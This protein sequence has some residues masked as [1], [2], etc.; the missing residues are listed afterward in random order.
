MYECTFVILGATGDLTKR[1]LIPAIYK[2]IEDKKIE[3]FSLIGVAITDT[4]SDTMLESAKGFIDHINEK[5]WEKLKKASYFSK[6]DFYNFEDYKNLRSL[7]DQVEKK[8]DLKG[9]RLFY[10]ATMP[11]HFATI[12]GA[13]AQSGIVDKKD[14]HKHS[15]HVGG[16]TRIVYEKPFGFDLKS[17]KKINREISKIF[18][19]DQI[20]RIDH[21]LG[22][23]VVGDIA[24]LRFTNRV[25]E[26]LWN[27]NN[28]DSVQIIM[29]EKIGIEGRGAF[30]DSCG[31][32]CDMIQSHMLQILSLVAMEAP[33]E[34]SGKYIRDAKAAVLKKVKAQNAIL[35]QYEGYKNER[36]VSKDSTTETFA[37]I[38]LKVQNKRWAGVPFYVKTGKYLDKQEVSIHIKFKMVKCLLSKSCP[39]DSNYLTIRVQPNEGFFLELNS[40]VVGVPNE[41]QP[42]RMD[43]SY[44]KTSGPNTPSAYEN[45]LLDVLR[46]DQSVFVRADEIE[47]SWKIVDQIK[48]L[49]TN[50]Y[51]YK[52]GS[53]GPRELELLDYPNNVRWRS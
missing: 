36:D 48:K 28:I 53:S 16:W 33:K 14:H 39:S 12:T 9:N 22:K 46:G 1:K 35:G 25:F 40:K 41:I 27:K 26:P 23:E 37:A 18:N 19:E 24:L 44:A 31:A 11:Q 38:T 43:F 5:S 42:V 15:E 34:L 29:S 20:F 2:L 52:K 21:Y 45:L 49:K 47:H 6:L 7:I 3:K 51:I 30:Y 4:N 32:I 10:L 17:A 50:I 13:L 8:Q